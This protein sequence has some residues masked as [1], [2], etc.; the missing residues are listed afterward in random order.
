MTYGIDDILFEGPDFKTRRYFSDLCKAC[1]NTLER[2]TERMIRLRISRNTF[3]RYFIRD[4]LLPYDEA[5]NKLD[6]IYDEIFR[7]GG[8]TVSTFVN[9]DGK[10]L[11][12]FACVEPIH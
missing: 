2:K 10:S 4:C 3:I 9:Y 5:Q 12:V 6:E 11:P 1:R 7:D 8:F